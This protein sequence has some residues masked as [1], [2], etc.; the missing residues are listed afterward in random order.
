[1]GR[2]A[3][4]CHVPRC[5]APFGTVAVSAANARVVAANVEA[6]SGPTRLAGLEQPG[7]RSGV[8]CEAWAKLKRGGFAREAQWKAGLIRS[9]LRLRSDRTGSPAGAAPGSSVVSITDRRGMMRI[10][11]SN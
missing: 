7:E 9:A 2:T 8:A 1:M 3:L 6:A 10:K 5:L 4:P 11:N